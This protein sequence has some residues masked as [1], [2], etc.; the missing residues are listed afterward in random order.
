MF[1]P[2]SERRVSF[3][4]WFGLGVLLCALACDGERPPE[5]IGFCEQLYTSFDI[6]NADRSASIAAVEIGSESPCMVSPGSCGARSNTDAAATACERV[7]M[8]AHR[9]GTCTLTVTSVS[10]QKVTAQI[11]LYLEP[12]DQKCRDGVGRIVPDIPFLRAD[13]PTVTIQFPAPDAGADGP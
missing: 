3:S 13:R 10:G 8:Y 1:A 9:T 2:R 7:K 5:R 12:S 6:I 4:S 11:D